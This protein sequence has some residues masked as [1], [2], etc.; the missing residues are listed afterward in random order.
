MIRVRN[1]SWQGKILLCSLAAA[2]I[3]LAT[4]LAFNTRSEEPPLRFEQPEID[5]CVSHD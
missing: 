5:L 1:L 2:G 4:G 3:G